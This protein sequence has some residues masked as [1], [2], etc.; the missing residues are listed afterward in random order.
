M[1]RLSPIL[2]IAALLLSA[3]EPSATPADRS[4]FAVLAKAAEG[5]AQA[6]PDR[7]LDFP[8]D[9]G[10]HP[11]FR[12]EWWY[13]T[14]NLKGSDGQEYGAQWTLFRS[15]V[16]PPGA[17]ETANP[18]Q[19]EQVYMAH[20]AL[21]GPDFHQA[22][23]RYARGGVHGGEARAGAMSEPFAAWLDDWSLASSGPEWL[24]LQVRAAQDDQALH[25]QL[26]SDQ[27]LVLQGDAG[28]SQKHPAGGGSHYYSHPFLEA[29]G[30]LRIDGRSVAVHG[31][32]WLDREW[33]SQ[34]LQPDQAGWD[35][36]ALHLDSGEKLMLFRLRA[37]SADEAAGGA[38]RHGVLISPRG[39]TQSLDPGLIGLEVM[40]RSAVAGRLLPL[41]W[42][43]ELPEIGRSMTVTAFH[44]DQWMDVDFP[45]WEG[46][47]T[48]SGD[49]AGSRGVGYLE[50]TGYS[51]Y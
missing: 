39:T 44:P 45:Y 21:T 17:F 23:Q 31:K 29:S 35:W 19:T 12:I 34:F 10:P 22:F 51:I 47:V 32:A 18:W 28:F 11:D 40:Q 30:K 3:C 9:H 27:P 1:S 48:V 16:R 7:A 13:L 36:F 46:M 2:L 25:L 42:R 38:F 8:R 50:L 20:F 24:P 26:D 41:E 14:A 49:D 5:Y 37:A 33:S 6:R 43:I 15:A 4:D